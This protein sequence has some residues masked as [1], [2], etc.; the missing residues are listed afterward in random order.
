VTIP[1]MYGYFVDFT[2]AT[3]FA[4]YPGYLITD[5]V[6]QVAETAT[7]EF[8]VCVAD[9]FHM[10]VFCGSPARP[11]VM[12]VETQIPKYSSY[13]LKINATFPAAE[14]RSWLD[15]KPVDRPEEWDEVEN[16]NAPAT[17][18]D[19]V[20]KHLGLRS[21]PIKIDPMKLP[22]KKTVPQSGIVEF[23]D[24]ALETTLPIAEKLSK[25]GMLLDAHM[26]TE[27]PH[28]MQIRQIPYSV[29]ADLPQ[30]TERLKT[31]NHNGMSLPDDECFGTKE[32][33]TDIHRLLTET[34][35][36]LDNKP[37]KQTDP[38]G[39]PIFSIYNGPGIPSDD[40]GQ[41]H[42]AIP[43]LFDFWTGG[44][45]IICDIMATEMHRGQLLFVYNTFP[46][47]VSY[48]DATQTYFTTYDLSEG[49]GTIALMLPYMSQE[50]FKQ[51]VQINDT[52][53]KTNAT[54][55][56][57]CFVQNALRGS[58]TVAP[59]VDIVLFKSYGKDFQLGVYGNMTSIK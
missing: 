1:W 52:K 42:D 48:A 7:V 3:G 50:P 15:N 32:K 29:A 49:R 54:G 16:V 56:L 58:D 34:K 19:S 11:T 10:G 46:E 17:M 37:W 41:L 26:I 13:K 9:D 27:Q 24:R 20:W 33:E 47:D 43:P 31:L 55:K 5:I 45:I 30:Y 38:E 4:R 21:A 6:S 36:W 18:S 22:I 53:G 51:T 39:T 57:T 59:D 35:S 25:L 14:R 23:I 28:P 40:A 8:Q 44:T 12:S 2:G